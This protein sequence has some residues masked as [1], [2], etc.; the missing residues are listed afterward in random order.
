[1]GAL[2]VL[3]QQAAKDGFVALTSDAFQ[4]EVV[5]TGHLRATHEEHLHAGAVALAGESEDVEVFLARGGEHLAFDGALDG[6]NLVAQHG[7]P[8]EVERLGSGVHL[9]T[10][11]V[12]H[13]R[14]LP[15][16][17]ER[18]LVDDLGVLLLGAVGGTGRDAALDVEVEA[19]AWVFPRYLLRAG[20][21]GEEFLQQVEGSAHG[22]RACIRPEVA[23]AILLDAPCNVDARP[24][25]LDIDLEVRVALVV[26]QADVEEGLMALDQ[27]RLEDE[28]FPGVG[29]DDV[30]EVL[31]LGA[32]GA[33][34]RLQA[35]GRAEIRAHPVP[36]AVPPSPHR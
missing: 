27:R 15:F 14:R 29:A 33:G 10:Q 34:L 32:Q 24:R 25:V 13:V 16:E 6:A 22:T 36:S 9:S 8:L 30:L 12:E 11:A 7:S 4:H 3:L 21:V 1:M 26:L 2:V 35:A 23:C 19:G 20:A 17:E 18:D 5:A 31:D 28:R